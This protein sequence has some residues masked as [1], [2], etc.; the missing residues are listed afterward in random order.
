MT[1]IFTAEE[2]I[3]ICKKIL[4]H[5]GYFYELSNGE[6]QLTTKGRIVLREVE[7]I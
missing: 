4:R 6:L 7:H 5:E 3:D 2:F 1:E